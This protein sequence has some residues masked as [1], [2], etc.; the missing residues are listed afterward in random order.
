MYQVQNS[1]QKEE[2]Y[3][4]NLKKYYKI[5]HVG[6]PFDGY[7]LYPIKTEIL[8]DKAFRI[9]KEINVDY[10]SFCLYLKNRFHFKNNYFYF[11]KKSKNTKWSNKDKKV[12]SDKERIRRDWRDKKNF[13]KDKSKIYSPNKYKKFYKK[14]AQKQHR[15][16]ERENINKCNWEH[17]LDY[18]KIKFFSDPWSWD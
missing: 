1:L 10:V 8:Y 3:K 14:Y 16:W 7:Y 18:K 2:W 11:Y 12:L 4:E 9:Y 13:R 15:Q 5:Y 6:N 17:L